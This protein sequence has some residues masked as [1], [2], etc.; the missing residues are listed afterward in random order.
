MDIQRHTYTLKPGGAPQG[1]Q[2]VQ[3]AS[4]PPTGHKG[5]KLASSAP[6]ARPGTHADQE[7]ALSKRKTG[8]EWLQAGMQNFDG[9]S[10]DIA[11]SDRG[12]GGGGAGEAVRGS[13]EWGR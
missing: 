12:K 1:T 4:S 5:A 2:S 7:T 9:E 11:R 10:G 3:L 8:G 13:G 6:S